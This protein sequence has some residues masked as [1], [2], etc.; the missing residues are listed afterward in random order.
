M[1]RAMVNKDTYIELFEYVIKRD[2]GGNYLMRDCLNNVF[3]SIVLIIFH[4]LHGIP[5]CVK[6][7]ERIWCYLVMTL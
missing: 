3:E 5:I 2:N 4:C 1:A 7:C 6:Q